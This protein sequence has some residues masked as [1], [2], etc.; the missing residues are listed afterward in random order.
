AGGEPDGVAECQ[1]DALSAAASDAARARPWASRQS[2]SLSEGTHADRGG[3]NYLLVLAAGSERVL[4]EARFL[5]LRELAVSH[6]RGSYEIDLA[7]DRPEFFARFCGDPRLRL[8]RADG[9]Q[10][11]AWRGAHDF[12][13]RMK[14]EFLRAFAAAHEGNFLYLDADV[15]PRRDFSSLFA[16][17]AGGE[18]FMHLPEGR[19][20]RSPWNE[21]WHAFLRDTTVAV[22][23]SAVRF[24]PNFVLWNAGVLGFSSRFAGALDDALDFVDDVYPRFPDRLTEQVAL[25]LCFA[26]RMPLV[27][28]DDDFIH[29]WRFKGFAGVVARLFETHRACGL[30]EIVR[31]SGR[32]LPE[33]L[34]PPPRRR[35]GER[36]Y[37]RLARPLRPLYEALRRLQ[38]TGRPPLDPA[39]LYPLVE[40]AGDSRRENP[41]RETS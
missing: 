28:A 25:T 10:L 37:H 41:A 29:Y 20:D 8:L 16:R 17:I 23:G 14:I 13:L 6:G 24:A 33:Q 26:R 12:I 2:G 22:G 38:A 39:R 3:R 15:Y 30:D 40:L 5:L 19:V 1:P 21:P 27:A 4:N 31:T 36:A 34:D 35:F 11:R 18:I 9:A 32:I 7:T